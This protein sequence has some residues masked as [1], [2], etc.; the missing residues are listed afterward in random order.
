MNPIKQ[1]SING[2]ILKE[3]GLSEDEVGQILDHIV[4][5]VELY[6]AEIGMT[7]EE[8]EE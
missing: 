8:L 3:S 1:F 7:V 4:D 6:G 5:I 2:V